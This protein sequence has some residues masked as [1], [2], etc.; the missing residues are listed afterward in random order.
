VKA[1]IARLLLAC[2]TPVAMQAPFSIF[3]SCNLDNTTSS[4]PSLYRLGYT[5]LWRIVTTLIHHSSFPKPTSS[6]MAQ[7]QADSSPPTR[8]ISAQNPPTPS[9]RASSPQISLQNATTNGIHVEEETETETVKGISKETLPEDAKSAANLPS[10]FGNAIVANASPY[11]NLSLHPFTNEMVFGPIPDREYHEGF[12]RKAIEMA[13]LALDSDETPVGCVFVRDGEVIGRGINGTNASLNVSTDVFPFLFLMM[14]R[15]LEVGWHWNLAF[16]SKHD[17]DTSAFF[18]AG[19][20][21]STHSAGSDRFAIRL[22][23]V[24]SCFTT[25][26]MTLTK[27]I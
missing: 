23:I 26:A 6:K 12:M 20:A 13:Q 16:G 25:C 2:V 10:G 14:V 1:N 22:Q 3:T 11:T 17:L 18:R 8:Q 7:E 5:A 27:R 9:S 15:D 21:H 4:F 24:G 19:R